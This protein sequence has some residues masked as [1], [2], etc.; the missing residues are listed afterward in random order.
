MDVNLELVKR[1]ISSDELCDKVNSGDNKEIYIKQIKDYILHLIDNSININSVI[2]YI[3]RYLRKFVLNKNKED[4]FFDDVLLK[5]YS[6]NIKDSDFLDILVDVDFDNVRQLL[7]K[8]YSECI[9]NN[10][11]V[12][13]DEVVK[14]LKLYYYTSSNHIFS[15]SFVNYFSYYLYKL[16]IVLDKNLIIFY[17]KQFSLSFSKSKEIT[18][19]FVALDDVLSSDPYYDNVRNKIILYKK[20]IGNKIDPIILSDIFYQITYLYI[21]NGINTNSSYTYDQLELVKEICLISILGEQYYDINYK[22]ISYSTQ[23]KKESISIV[24]DYF[25]AL[26]INISLDDKM[27][28]IST[29]KHLDDNTDKAIS[30]DV[31]FDLIL[32]RESPNL[33]SSLVRNYPVL[34]CEYKNNRKKSLLDLILDIYSNK[35][36]LINLN[37]DLEWHKK[38]EYDF[39]IISPKIEKLNNKIDVCNSYISVMNYIIMKCDMSSYDLLRSIS[40]LITYSHSNKMVKEDIYLVLSEVIPKKI[41]RLCEGRNNNYK[42][43]LKRKVIKCYLD[44]LELVK[45]QLDTDYFMRLYSTLQL[46]ISS[47]DS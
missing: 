30:V 18:T 32:K 47:F 42:E 6:L 39:N 11:G 33:I 40:D 16:D 21:L 29:D 41:S 5:C 34:G 46:C 10:I 22:D 35:R 13:R 1:I 38:K 44:S 27:N 26:G 31:L 15:V 20:N 17:Y 19:S 43:Y 23:L 14:M 28:F 8:K 12:S 2:G 25:R 4:A 24:T 37:K 7:E 9:S 36:L 45:S 3:N